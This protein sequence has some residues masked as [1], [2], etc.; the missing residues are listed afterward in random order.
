MASYLPY[1]QV[2]LNELV[3]KQAQKFYFR[4]TDKMTQARK[5]K[6]LTLFTSNQSTHILASCSTPQKNPIPK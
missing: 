2:L 3:L 5:Q 1:G 6:T 4:A